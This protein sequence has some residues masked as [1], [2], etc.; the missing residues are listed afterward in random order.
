M[1]L[2]KDGLVHSNIE[3]MEFGAINEAFRRLDAGD[4]DGRLV[5]RF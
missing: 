2:A 4:A 5:V 3:T 1:Q